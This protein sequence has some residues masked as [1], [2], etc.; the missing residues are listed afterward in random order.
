MIE[1]YELEQSYRPDPEREVRVRDEWEHD[2]WLAVVWADRLGE[3]G[4]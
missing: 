1:G 4:L 2:E 3:K